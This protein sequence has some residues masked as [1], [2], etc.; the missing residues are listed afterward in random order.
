MINVFMDF[1]ED[2]VLVKTYFNRLIDDIYRGS[3][4]DHGI[5]EKNIFR[6]EP[7]T[8]VSYKPSNSPREIRAMDTITVDG[9]T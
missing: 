7:Y 5:E 4:R 9:Q 1:N 6:I 2:A 8:S 3:Y